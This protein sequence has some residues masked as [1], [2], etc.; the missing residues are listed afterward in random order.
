MS[1]FQ[2]THQIKGLSSGSAHEDLKPFDIYFS[3]LMAEINE[4]EDQ[5]I[6][7][8]FAK[9]SHA[10]NRQNS[11]LDLTQNSVLQE[12]LARLKHIT[13]I[14]SDE[15]LP[16]TIATPLVLCAGKLYLQKFYQYELNI[17]RQLI[18]RNNL[19]PGYNPKILDSLFPPSDN[20]DEASESIDWQKVAAF[21]SL[22]RQLCI[23][24]G[25]PG[26]GK[27]STV[28][29]ILAALMNQ[30]P[31]LKVKLAAPTGKAAARLSESISD[32]LQYLPSSLLS[33]LS[34]NI[35][36]KVTTI[37]RLL[38]MRAEGQSY[39]Y[40]SDRKLPLDLLILDES[41]MIDLAMFDKI[42]SALPDH[43]RLIMLGDPDQLLSVESGAVMNDLFKL[44]QHYDDAFLTE[45]ED[46]LGYDRS[47]FHTAQSSEQ[48][49]ES[50]ASE[51]KI[52]GSVLRNVFCHLIRSY[53]FNASMGIGK[54]ASSIQNKTLPEFS[55]D[56]EISYVTEFSLSSLKAKLSE[57]Y[58]GYLDA[59]RHNLEPKMLLR[60]F[61]K[62]RIL[63]PMRE[64][65]MGIIALNEMLESN[66]HISEAHQ[67][68]YHG[69][70]IMITRND[71]ALG[72]FNG[73]IGICFLSESQTLKVIFHGLNGEF[74][75]FPISALSHYETCFV[76]S[77][78]KSQGSEFDAISIVLP[79]LQKN[80]HDLYT[81]ELIYTA[82][83]R[84]RRHVSIFASEEDFLACLSKDN[85]RT[86]GL[87][88][89]L[90]SEWQHQLRN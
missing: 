89:R 47:T 57:Q 45:I 64:G 50:S 5:E 10:V 62:T 31:D 60:E 74:N 4:V 9:L 8:T 20:S 77:I 51:S 22:S 11:C 17:A 73:D 66:L 41:S 90:L 53:R 80:T 84:A 56:D 70:P 82:I 19:I 68:F 63:T 59:V 25:G 46:A 30:N 16:S 35:P 78:H 33:T 12:K 88:D 13:V 6:K 42:L 15:S 1:L 43:C 38:G 61:E 48:F 21:Q 83:T 14:D 7:N 52:E 87:M 71:Y 55:N 3:N 26:T 28:A 76:M 58:Q 40:H 36:T 2:N 81:R 65:D 23:I 85:E 39:K 34:S 67:S 44:G 27:T 24:T 29:K 72:L 37:H 75:T 49:A 69:K 86:S 79:P 18:K 54:L 32:S